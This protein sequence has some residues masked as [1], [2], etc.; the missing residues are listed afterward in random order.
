MVV[1]LRRAAPEWTKSKCLGQATS[2]DMDPWFDN[3][4]HGFENQQE[5]G[6]EVCNGTV[7]GIVCPIRDKCL[8]FALVNNERFGVW[9]G[10]SEID[11]RAIRK[12]WPWPGGAEPHDEWRWYPP[13]EVAKMLPHR[14]RAELEQEDD[15]GDD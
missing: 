7:D 8:L 12:M 6:Q 14:H 15:D 13:G 11:R 2:P 9:G 1:R 5:L 4:E 3:T 10:T